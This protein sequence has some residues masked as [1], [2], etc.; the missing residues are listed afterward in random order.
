MIAKRSFKLAIP[1]VGTAVMLSTLMLTPVAQAAPTDTPGTGEEVRIGKTLE[2]S[3]LIGISGEEPQDVSAR[4]IPLNPQDVFECDF[5]NNPDH[6]V[7]E[8]YTYQYGGGSEPLVWTGGDVDLECGTDSSSGYK[9]IRQRHQY[10][11]PTLPN[12]WETVRDSASD[13]LGYTSPQVWD[14]YMVH[15]I[16]D[17]LDYSLPYPRDIGND[18]TCF[19][20][21]FHI[22]KG[23]QIFASYYVNTILSSSNY[24]VVTAY[25]STNSA[26]SDCTQE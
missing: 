17:S 3:T 19:S 12:A 4:S 26:Y 6:V 1:I 20:A 10:P 22:Y 2:D 24:I 23:A 25:P 8:I 14:E 13:A 21:P 7:L 18:K 15:A 11:T 9:H 5:N 16:H